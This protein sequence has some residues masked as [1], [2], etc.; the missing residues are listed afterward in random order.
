MH[1]EVIDTSF[2]TVDHQGLAIA[3]EPAGAQVEHHAVA[4]ET[5]GFA[6]MVEIQFRGGD[7]VFGMLIVA[8]AHGVDVPGPLGPFHLALGGLDGHLRQIGLLLACQKLAAD[9]DFLARQRGV[10][11]V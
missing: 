9:L 6:R 7:F 5:G 1:G 3:L 10:Q 4:L 2:E 11:T 8:L